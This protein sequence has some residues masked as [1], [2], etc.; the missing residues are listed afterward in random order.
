MGSP[1]TVV[2]RGTISEQNI[3]SFPLGFRN[4]T[5]TATKI[6]PF[7]KHFYVEVI[8]LFTAYVL[9]LVIS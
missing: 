9:L 7:L 1:V 8:S 2:Q 5:F 4:L 6:T 3:K